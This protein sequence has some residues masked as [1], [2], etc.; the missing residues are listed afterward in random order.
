MRKPYAAKRSLRESLIQ[1]IATQEDAVKAIKQASAVF[2]M[3]GAITLM[4]TLWWK[5]TWIDG[6]LYILIGALSYFLHS[7]IIAAG[8]I[9]LS[10]LAFLNTL[11][12][13]LN[14]I[15]GGGTNIVMSALVFWYGYQAFNATTRLAEF[16]RAPK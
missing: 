7:R 8:L 10:G 6:A 14:S 3:V 12:N 5:G 1:P 11:N 15:P 2:I 13:M 16:R 4:L 9:L